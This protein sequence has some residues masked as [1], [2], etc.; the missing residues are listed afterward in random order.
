MSPVRTAL[1]TAATKFP[2]VFNPLLIDVVVMVAQ[3]TI[4]SICRR[5]CACC[6]IPSI[7]DHN[8]TRV[9]VFGDTGSGTLRVIR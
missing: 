7:N 5:G 1:P 4:D 2:I 9:F 3:G 8:S 6:T